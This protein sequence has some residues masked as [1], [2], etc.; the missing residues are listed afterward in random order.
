VQ[1][2]VA[3]N[4]R[5]ARKEVEATLKGVFGK[6]YGPGLDELALIAIILPDRFYPEVKKY[7]ARKKEAEFRLYIDHASFLA[8]EP[9]KRTGMVCD[10]VIRAVQLLPE[11]GAKN[12]DHRRLTAEIVATARSKGW[13][14]SDAPLAAEGA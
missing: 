2:D 14:I 13:S 3:D 10:A 5:E 1:A 8:A 12:I 9:Q 7:S 6:D 11:V 4:Y